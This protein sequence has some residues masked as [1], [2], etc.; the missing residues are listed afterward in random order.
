LPELCRQR[1][2]ET[3]GDYVLWLL[4]GL[5]VTEAGERRLK[6]PAAHDRE[7]LEALYEASGEVIAT[8]LASEPTL[9]R[10][11]RRRGERLLREGR[12]SA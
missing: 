2:L 5:V 4:F 12:H 7:L 6:S 9:S 8:V 3:P 1:G 10:R 11:T